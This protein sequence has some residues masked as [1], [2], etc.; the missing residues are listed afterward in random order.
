[1]AE[2]VT[3]TDA[4]VTTYKTYRNVH[5]DNHIETFVRDEWDMEITFTR[6]AKPIEAGKWYE[7]DGETVFVLAIYGPWAWLTDDPEEMSG[8]KFS[9]WSGKLDELT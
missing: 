9:S 2:Q 6:R 3:F 1:M 8:G 5:H 4:S 7:R